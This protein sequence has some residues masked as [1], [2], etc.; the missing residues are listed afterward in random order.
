MV[1]KHILA[2]VV[3]ALGVAA[4]AA[5]PRLEPVTASTACNVPGIG[6][7]QSPWR[8]VRGASFTYCVPSDWR[9]DSR[10]SATIDPNNWS[11]HGGSIGWGFGRAP[12]VEGNVV[13]V[14]RQQ[15]LA[16]LPPPCPQPWT[17]DESVDGRSVRLS[18][19]ECQGTH[20]TAAVFNQ[21]MMYFQGAARDAG[22]AQVELT[23]FRSLRFA[24]RTQ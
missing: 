15:D 5:G 18:H 21:P 6:S 14:V 24:A 16:T 13:T 17:A 12:V 19:F 8:R 11:G 3:I 22:T 9:P 1:G 23:I 10:G 7:S 4:C 20:H 2:T